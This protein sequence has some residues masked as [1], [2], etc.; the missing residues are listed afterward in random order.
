ME[1]ILFVVLL[2]VY[3]QATIVITNPLNTDF[4]NNTID[5]FYANFG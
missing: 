1:K 4:T 3:A 5:Y 2:F